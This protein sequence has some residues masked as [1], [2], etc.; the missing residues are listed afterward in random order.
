MVS[1]LILSFN[2]GLANVRLRMGELENV[3]SVVMRARGRFDLRPDAG[4]AC[5]LC[6]ETLSR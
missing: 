4:A 2:E 5:Q 1:K 3:Y 6:R